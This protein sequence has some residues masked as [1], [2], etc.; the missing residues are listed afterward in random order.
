MLYAWQ[1]HHSII[2][3]EFLNPSQALNADLYFQ[4]VQRVHENLLRTCPML[5]NKRNI[6]LMEVPMV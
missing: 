3:F 5:I 2:Y 1:D 4:Q 6:D